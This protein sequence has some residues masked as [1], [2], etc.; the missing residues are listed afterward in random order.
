MTKPHLRLKPS[1]TNTFF[2]FF[3]LA[4]LVALTGCSQKTTPK[5]SDLLQKTDIAANSFV[6]YL[7]PSAELAVGTKGSI[8][9]IE[10]DEFQVKLIRMIQQ[11]DFSRDVLVDLEKL[12]K[13]GGSKL[14][15]ELR[16]HRDCPY[17]A[18]VNILNILTE[19]EIRTPTVSVDN[20]YGPNPPDHW[21]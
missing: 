4:F 14:K 20:S 12:K 18:V 17:K 15:V 3:F 10:K 7:S 5:P 8:Q 13:Q 2:C 6:I 19:Y 21:K 16:P 1:S 9:R 11:T